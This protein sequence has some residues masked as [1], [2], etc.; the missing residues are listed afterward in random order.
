MLDLYVQSAYLIIMCSLGNL[1]PS[2]NV[3]LEGFWQEI[4][5]S[6]NGLE[7]SSCSKALTI[8]E[9]VLFAYQTA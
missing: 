1:C 7:K 9:V 3:V 6:Q 5:I 4:S 2:Q 8:L